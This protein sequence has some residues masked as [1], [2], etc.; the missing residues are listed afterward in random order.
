MSR[1]TIIILSVALTLFGVIV[2]WL[3]IDNWEENYKTIQ[4]YEYT[5]YTPDAKRNRFLAAEK[6]LRGLDIDAQSI[7]TIV[8]LPD[9]LPL[10]GTVIMGSSANGWSE[11][12]RDDYLDW[13][14]AG[15]HLVMVATTGYNYD[16]RSSQDPMLDY[17]GVQPFEPEYDF[18][19]DFNQ[20]TAD[21]DTGTNLPPDAQSSQSSAYDSGQITAQW[22]NEQS[23]QLRLYPDYYLRHKFQ[24]RVNPPI[25]STG[26]DNGSVILVFSYGYGYLTVVSDLSW[27]N[28][29]RIAKLDH[30]AFFWQLLQPQASH[31]DTLKTPDSLGAVWLQY[32]D[33]GPRW[34]WLLWDAI[35]S[36]LIAALI[37]LIALLWASTLRIGPPIPEPDTGRRSLLEHVIASARFRWRLRQQ[38]Q[39]LSHARQRIEWQM[40]RQHPGWQRLEEDERITILAEQHDLKPK[41]VEFALLRPVQTEREFVTAICTL[42]KLQST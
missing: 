26:N 18:I 15:G 19:G 5:E 11:D 36:V 21:D 16:L 13:I 41:T 30:G 29:Q 33:I 39:L 38:S 7:E 22:L 32:L 6:L 10:D 8:E 17:F 9:S 34:W 25:W 2:L 31:A 3:A 1:T 28:N 20:T 42:Q 4:R 23:Y 37:I 12:R 35:W 14:D 40:L 27:I 24:Q